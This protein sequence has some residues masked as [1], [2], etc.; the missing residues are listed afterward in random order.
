MLRWEHS[1]DISGTG[2]CGG[3]EQI[4]CGAWDRVEALQVIGCGYPQRIEADGERTS[5]D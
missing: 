3:A 2:I 4:R 1:S 5:Q